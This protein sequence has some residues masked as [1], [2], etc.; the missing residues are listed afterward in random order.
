MH[1]SQVVVVAAASFLF[2]SKAIAVTADTN[3]AKISMVARGGP[4]QR[5]LRYKPVKDDS[6]D[7]DDLDDLGETEERGFTSD[8]QALAR[9]WSLSYD[10]IAAGT[11]RLTHDQQK[12]WTAIV[13]KA[14]TKSQRKNREAYNAKWRKENGYERRV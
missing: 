6:Y 1:L 9:S 3:Q 12:E 11:Q 13:N 8:L 2:A 14:I 4:S 5:L 10:D 7:I